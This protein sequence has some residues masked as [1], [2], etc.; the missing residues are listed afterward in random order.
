MSLN[1][2]QNETHVYDRCD[3]DSLFLSQLP[4]AMKHVHDI[5]DPPRS[6]FYFGGQVYT[7]HRH[8]LKCKHCNT[9][10]C[11]R[12]DGLQC[13]RVVKSKEQAQAEEEATWG[14]HRGLPKPSSALRLARG[15]TRSCEQPAGRQTQSSP[16]HFSVGKIRRRNPSPPWNASQRTWCKRTAGTTPAR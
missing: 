9:D 10:V 1:G 6:L 5:P 7:G 3:P 4:K 8:M 11:S 12:A 16:Q 13:S 15:Q 14:Q 2:P